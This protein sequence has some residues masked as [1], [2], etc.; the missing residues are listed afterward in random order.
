[1]VNKSLKIYFGEFSGNGQIPK[2]RNFRAG[3]SFSVSLL[4]LFTLNS[5][6][7]NF[8]EDQRIVMT[9]D[10]G[11]TN[12]VFSA[13]QAG[14]EVIQPITLPAPADNIAE[15][16]KRIID[17]FE[18][19]K[20]HLKTA[21]VAISFAFP[22][23]A[24]YELGIIGDLV[25]LPLFRGGVALG[26]MLEAHFN[27][28]VFLNNDGDLFTYGEAI[29]G[30]LPHINDLLEKSGSPK[31]FRNLLGGTFGTGFGGGIVSSGELLRGDNSAG[32]EINRMRNKVHP[33]YSVEET[34]SI[35]GIRRN[36]SRAAGI[37]E[38]LCPT[39]QSIFEIGMG[40][41]DGNKEAARQAFKKFAIAAG[42]ALANAITLVDG[43]IVLGGGI[44]GAYPLFLQHLVNEMNYRFETPEGKYLPRLE[45]KVFNLENEK[46]L[47]RF[48]TGDKREIEVPF[49]DKKISYDPLQRIGV[50]VTRLGTSKATSLGAYAFALH[51]LNKK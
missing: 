32:G 47:Q 38:I 18:Q 21:P 44:S 25:N 8:K 12:F 40:K 23:P 20:T 50:G 7:M 1:M 14:E 33:F 41:V 16:L 17:G 49:S 22:G 10:A 13:I 39:P 35:R 42:D 15:L 2:N 4:P 19:V 27:I 36:Y 11:G 46:E 28:P 24:N 9:L 31:R 29:G 37:S 48:I 30:F 5:K 45:I 3:N 51:E 6:V 34:V 43:L 26:P